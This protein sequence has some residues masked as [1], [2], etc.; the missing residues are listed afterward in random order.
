MLS[1][2]YLKLI[3][4]RRAPIYVPPYF[5]TAF[6]RRSVFVPVLN[7]NVREKAPLAQQLSLLAFLADLCL[8]TATPPQGYRW[9][10]YCPGE[11]LSTG[12]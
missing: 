8:A 5:A 3:S 7:A 1:I 2:N 6:H 4:L 11:S 9:P 12:M 10:I